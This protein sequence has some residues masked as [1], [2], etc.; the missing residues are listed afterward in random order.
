MDRQGKLVW[1]SK[2]RPGR[3]IYLDEVAQPP[4]G[5]LWDDIPPVQAQ[6]NERLGYPTQK[7]L[8]LLERIIQT[9]SNPG[10]VVLDPFAG[11]GTTVAAA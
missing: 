3:K 6:A 4:I 9:S 10:D 11:C 8:A 5:N 7:P 2:G 1:S